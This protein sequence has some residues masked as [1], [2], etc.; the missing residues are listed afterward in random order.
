MSFV[1][2]WVY[3]R[4]K[5]A[6][7][8]FRVQI[9]LVEHTLL[10]V[11]IANCKFGVYVHILYPF[12]LSFTL[13]LF[14]FRVCAIYNNN[15]SVVAVFSLSWLTVLGTSIMI[16]LGASASNIGTTN[17]CIQTSVKPYAKYSGFFPLAH[18]T[19][20]FVATSWGFLRNSYVGVSFKNMYK[21]MILGK[22]LPGFSK[23]ILH[24]G[25]AY[26]L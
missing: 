5:S 12:T 15:R 21:V 7:F 13:L 6:Y 9:S 25:Q 22:H 24:D 18:D 11:P 10:A 23:S 3:Y 4:A 2:R 17:Y 19:L 14:V 8:Q 16:P 1:P 20:V 26:F